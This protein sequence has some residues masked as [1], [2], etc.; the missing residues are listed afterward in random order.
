MNWRPESASDQ[1]QIS[2]RLCWYL[3]LWHALLMR[4]IVTALIVVSAFTLSACGASE[5]AAPPSTTKLTTTTTTT[6]TTTVPVT[7]TTLSPQQAAQASYFYIVAETNPLYDPINEQYQDAPL[8]ET[9]AYCGEMANVKQRYGQLLATTVWPP[10][11]QPQVTD[12][13]VKNSALT[14]LY[15]ECADLPGNY[16]ALNAIGSDIGLAM[17]SA[18]AAISTLRGV[19]GLPIDR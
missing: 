5:T 2:R 11:Y 9:P 10:E 8:S 18:N 13:I 7:V 1:R 19:L 4:K 3:Q 12:V 16:E 15:L 17:D 14:Q 6:T